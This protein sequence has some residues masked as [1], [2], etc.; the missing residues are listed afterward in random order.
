MKQ[1]RVGLKA[2]VLPAYLR[3][4]LMAARMQNNEVVFAEFNRWAEALDQGISRIITEN[5]GTL[6][7]VES[8]VAY[9]HHGND[10]V[11]YEVAIHVLACEGAVEGSGA[12]SIRFVA[13]WELTSVGARGAV[14]GRGTFTAQPTMW[15][16]KNFGQLA[17]GLSEAVAGLSKSV[18]QSL[19]TKPRM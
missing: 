3:T 10:A 16:G 8:V 18:G 5:L 7:N 4:K 2:I 13:E 14:A 1:W 15:D 6:P 11:D 9:P 12:A 17:R 19:P